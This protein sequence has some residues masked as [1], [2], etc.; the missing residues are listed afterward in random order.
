[1]TFTLRPPRGQS[2]AS[3]HAQEDADKE[4]E[5]LRGL[6]EEVRRQLAEQQALNQASGENGERAEQQQSLA[7]DARSA[8]SQ[9]RGI[10]ASSG[11]RGDPRAAAEELDRAA[12]LQDDTAEALAGEDGEASAELG[13]RAPKPWRRPCGNSRPNW[14]PD[15]YD[16]EAHP[17][18]YERLISD[19]LRSISYE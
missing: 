16:S 3:Q 11:R 14:K 9:A 12:G 6:M 10:P 17:P 7:Q 8:A 1:M 18:G 15:A 2:S 5:A 13:A 19:Y 4:R